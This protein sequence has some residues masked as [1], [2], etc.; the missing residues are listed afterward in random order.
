MLVGFT[1]TAGAIAGYASGLEEK[2]TRW[3]VYLIGVLVAAVIF[4]IFDLDRPNVGFI[5]VPQQPMMDTA[6]SIAS[7]F[8]D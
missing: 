3:L 1:I 5:T 2:R 6:A 8:S 4:V 7:F